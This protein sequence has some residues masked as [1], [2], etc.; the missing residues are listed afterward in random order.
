MLGSWWSHRVGVERK[1]Q[2][3]ERETGPVELAE[4]LDIG[5]NERFDLSG[6]AAALRRYWSGLV[7]VFEGC[8]T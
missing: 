8:H 1:I 6:M 3:N 2:K 4:V 7:C 5:P